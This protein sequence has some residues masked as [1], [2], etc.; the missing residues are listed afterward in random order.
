MADWVSRGYFTQLLE[1]G[2]RVSRY[3]DAMI[4]AK[5]ATVDGTWS[6]V[7]TANIDR[8]SLQGNFE[9]NVEVIDES[10]A[11]T[12]QEI[13]ILDESNC[14]PMTPQRVGGARP[15]PQVHRVRPRPLAPASVTQSY[16]YD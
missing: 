4:H 9:I 2:V 8:L 10:F 13:F 14:L 16:V 12:L 11:K 3:R 15:A 5:T 7:G 6:T 1:A